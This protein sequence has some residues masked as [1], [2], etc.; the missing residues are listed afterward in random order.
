[1]GSAVFQRLQHPDFCVVT[2]RVHHG[3][4][5]LDLYRART[6]GPHLTKG[7]AHYFGDSIPRENR[8]APLHH[9][10]EDFE[11]V[12][13]LEGRRRRGIDDPEAMLRSDDDDGHAL[14]PR[15]DHP[16]QKIRGAGPGIA[17]HGGHLPCSLVQPFRHVDGGSLVTN[18]HEPHFV[19]LELGEQRID[20]GTR[21][22]KDEAHTL[23]DETS[24][25]Q[26]S[27]GDFAHKIL[28]PAGLA[29]DEAIEAAWPAS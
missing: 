1:A 8:T 18:R 25:Q 14:V 10:L 4:R 24:Q 6:P 21:D 2:G 5:Y 20:L 11:L 23:G 17:K 22:P 29:A 27:S 12:L 15:S 3:R 26:L 16:G 13:A 7:D 28:L 9:R 19:L